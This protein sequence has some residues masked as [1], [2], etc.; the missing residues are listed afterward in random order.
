LRNQRIK[1]EK[2]KNFEE[3]S[4]QENIKILTNKILSLEKEL[5]DYNE[6]YNLKDEFEILSV[7]NM[8]II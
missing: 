3:N 2:E 4:Y 5:S 1:F 8:I 7:I 6:K